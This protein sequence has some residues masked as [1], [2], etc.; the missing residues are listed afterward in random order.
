MMLP[1]RPRKAKETV[2]EI[3]RS[4]FLVMEKPVEFNAAVDRFLRG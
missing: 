4:D 2:L 3:D 1:K